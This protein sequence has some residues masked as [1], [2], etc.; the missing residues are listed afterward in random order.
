MH[1]GTPRWT[2]VQNDHQWKL[3]GWPQFGPHVR[4]RLFKHDINGD[5]QPYPHWRLRGHQH[6]VFAVSRQEYP[7]T[8]VTITLEL[9]CHLDREIQLPA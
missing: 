3:V 4:A 5:L 2:L 9:L 8:P 6:H 7:Q 1:L